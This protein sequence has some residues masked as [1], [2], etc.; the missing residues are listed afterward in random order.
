ML[1]QA[2]APRYPACTFQGIDSSSKQA[3]RFNA[4]VRD[5]DGVSERRVYAVVGDLQDPSA[6]IKQR[7]WFDFDIAIMSMALHHVSDPIDML[8]RLRERLKKGGIILVVE[9]ASESD[10]EQSTQTTTSSGGEVH[11]RER[12]GDIDASLTVSKYDPANMIEVIGGQ[13]IWPGF[14]GSA[15]KE[16]MTAAGCRDVEV[17]VHP[18][19]FRVPEHAGGHWGLKRLLFAKGVVA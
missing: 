12:K 1:T 13:K 18:E 7:E 11:S 15:T 2:L 9:W 14:T 17:R 10:F 16:A 19:E 5:L 6:E 3:E 8:T 4:A